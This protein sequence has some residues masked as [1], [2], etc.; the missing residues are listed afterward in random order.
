MKF[1]DRF[2]A[3]GWGVKKTRPNLTLYS[4]RSG[5]VK[6]QCYRGVWTALRYME[7]VT[8]TEKHVIKMLEVLEVK[9]T[10]APMSEFWA[11]KVVWKENGDLGQ[12]IID[13]EHYHFDPKQSGDIRGMGHGGRTFYIEFF[14]GRTVKTSNL[15]AQGRIDCPKARKILQDNARFIHPNKTLIKALNA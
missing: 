13:G 15:W 5:L 3:I 7:L 1:K 10:N 2:E 9:F 8:V 4:N 11:K 6:L 12:A 14:D